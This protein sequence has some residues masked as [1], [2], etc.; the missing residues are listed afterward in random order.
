MTAANRHRPTARP[1][2]GRAC[3]GRRRG[4]GQAGGAWPRAVLPLLALVLSACAVPW[5]PDH[6]D[7][8]DRVSLTAGDAQ[9]RNI[10]LQ[11][12]NTVPP[13]HP[14]PQVTYDGQRALAVMELFYERVGA[15][16]QGETGAS[17][18]DGS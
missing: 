1:L 5:D 10:R 4:A 18:S 12:V 6:P 13:Q 15:P 9:Q 14:L 7:R 17:I 16:P 3:E 11:A 2:G 8:L